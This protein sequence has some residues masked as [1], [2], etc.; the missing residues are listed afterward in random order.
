MVWKKVFTTKEKD[1][2]KRSGKELIKYELKVYNLV[3]SVRVPPKGVKGTDH[4]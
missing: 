2:T 4:V 1:V 3:R